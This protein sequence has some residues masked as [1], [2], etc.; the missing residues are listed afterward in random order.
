MVDLLCS[1]HMAKLFLSPELREQKLVTTDPTHH[2]KRHPDPVCR[3]ATIHFPDTD[4]ETDRHTDR[5]TYGLDDS[6]I[7]WALMLAILIEGDALI[8]GP[9]LLT[10]LLV[11]TF[12]SA[13]I[14][15]LW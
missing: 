7:P 10:T 15:L 12:D 9:R 8:I 3:F 1:V 4:T 2:P 11:V 13:R 14:E 5:P 6:S